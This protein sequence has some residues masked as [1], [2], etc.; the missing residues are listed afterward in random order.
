MPISADKTL[1]ELFKFRIGQLKKDSEDATGNI[2]QICRVVAYGLTAL[3]IPFLTSDP[4]RLPMALQH[5]PMAVVISAMLGGVS[6]ILEFFQN[7]YADV[8]AKDELGRIVD[9]LR[10]NSLIIS[11]PT[12]FM[13]SKFKKN[14]GKNKRTHFFLAK[15]GTTCIG[16]TIIFVTI[17]VEI[18][19]M[20][21]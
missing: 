12:E 21:N 11:T 9:N 4:A 1:E 3:I 7:Y 15:L 13:S 18:S 19:R 2:S 20:P 5:Y 6:I 8:Y 17:I 10:Q 14:D 16:V